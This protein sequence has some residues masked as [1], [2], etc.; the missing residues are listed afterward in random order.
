MATVKVSGGLVEVSAGEVINGG[1]YGFG[2]NPEELS[3]LEAEHLADELRAA[4]RQARAAVKTRL[5]GPRRMG[6]L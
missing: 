2:L 3:A 4:A 5:L 1:V 6:D